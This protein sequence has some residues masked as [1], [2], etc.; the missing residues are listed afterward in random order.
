MKKPPP[1]P[2]PIWQ[3]AT[4]ASPDF[5]TTITVSPELRQI[6]RRVV[7]YRDFAGLHARVFRD[8][9]ELQ[10]AWSCDLYDRIA[11]AWKYVRKDP[12]KYLQPQPAEASGVRHIQIG[13][14]DFAT[15]QDM[16]AEEIESLRELVGLV[17]QST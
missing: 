15:L 2:S 14:I 8:S 11:G 9:G 12:N 16:T 4:T 3:N 6:A 7:L 17:T 13:G 1:I 10:S 5:I